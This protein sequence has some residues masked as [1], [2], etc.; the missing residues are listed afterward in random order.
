MAGLN[1]AWAG[2]IT[3]VPTAQGWLYVAVVWDL[4]SRKVVGWSMKD[5]L[6]Q[7]LVHEALEMAVERRFSTTVSERL[8]FHEAGV[9]CTP[10]LFHF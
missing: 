8:L 10:I 2:D 6:E 5:S 9:T 7:A 4:K 3:Y 1:R